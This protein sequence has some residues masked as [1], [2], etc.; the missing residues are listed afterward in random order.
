MS[1]VVSIA[2][3]RADQW[4]LVGKLD[5]IPRLG[6]RVV[7]AEQGEIAIFRNAE[8]GLFALAN[9]CPHRGGPLSE[10][11]VHGH[12]VTCPLHNWRIEMESGEVVAP[13][14]GC[15]P[16]YAVRLEGDAIYLNLEPI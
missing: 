2:E 15:V 5:D 8:D 9:S 4:V 16:R 13:D 14:Q 3:A 10:G 11:I 1:N 6:A 12:R 7:Q